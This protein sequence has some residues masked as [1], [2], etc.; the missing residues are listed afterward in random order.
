MVDAKALLDRFLGAA[1][2]DGHLDNTERARIMA[3]VDQAGLDAEAKA[4]LFD[5]I[6]KPIGVSEVAAAATTQEQAAELYL[7]SRL[8]IAP[9]TA[10]ERAY[11]EALAHRLKL[12]PDLVAHLDRQAEA[13][14]AQA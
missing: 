2:A 14:A 8:T 6:E 12:P 7:A 4:F 11:L 1:R 10:D 5:H 3:Q 13:S 9:D